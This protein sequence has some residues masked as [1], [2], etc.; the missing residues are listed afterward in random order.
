MLVSSAIL[1]AVFPRKQTSPLRAAYIS[2]ESSMQTH[3]CCRQGIEI[4]LNFSPHVTL[5]TS[6]R[7]LQVDRFSATRL[8]GSWCD[9]PMEVQA[10]MPLGARSNLAFPFQ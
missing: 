2:G 9:L 1:D 10:R 8:R 6:G 4:F 3:L 7:L 5:L